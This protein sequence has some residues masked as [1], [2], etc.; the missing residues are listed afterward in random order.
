MNT[1][2]ISETFGFF[3][4]WL[5]NPLRVAAIVPSGQALAKAM[6]EEISAA[7][8]PVIELGPG[9]G[10]FTR[11]LLRRGIREEDLALIEFGSEFAASLQL[12]YP[13]AHTIWM[14]A[15]RLHRVQLFGGRQ[16]GAVVSG[17][18]VL[19][20]PPRKVIAILEG[21]FAKMR[22]G[23]AFYQFTYGPACPIPRVLLD[24]LGLKA[25]R[26][27]GTLA[28]V[29]PASVYRIRQ[30]QPRPSSEQGPLSAI[31]QDNDPWSPVSGRD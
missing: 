8:G 29:P 26:I 18:P 1:A 22:P 9:T 12:R 3:R 17:L 25:T 27:G 15:S 28:N 7:S 23:G 31:R 10:S 30:R 6:T 20:M 14:D 16:A 21:C 19:S 11:A 13:R 5:A 24:R 4:A 2:M